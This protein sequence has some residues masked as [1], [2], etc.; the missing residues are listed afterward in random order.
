MIKSISK[1]DNISNDFLYVQFKGIP[2][3]LS[4]YPIKIN[5]SGKNIMTSE[6]VLLYGIYTNGSCP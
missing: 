3:G 5:I 2:Y 6:C 1:S 4:S